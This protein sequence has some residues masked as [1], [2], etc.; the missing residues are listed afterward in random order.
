MRTR[1]CITLAVALLFVS[2]A[3]FAGG[4]GESA[5]GAAATA[6]AAEGNEAPMLAQMV[7]AGQLPPLEDRIPLE[8]KITNE[9]A[10]DQLDYEIGRYGGTMR[11][12]TSV[13]E[14]DADVFVMCNE[15][16]VNT[17]GIRGEVITGNI[18]KDYEVSSNQQEFTF[19]MREGLKWSDGEAVTTEDVSFAVEDFLYNEQLVPIFPSWLRSGGS[20]EGNPLELEVVD[21]Y[22]FKLKF[23]K[24]YGG[25]LI[26]VAI[27]GWRGYTDLLK[28]AHFLKNFHADYT[29]VENLEQ[30]IAERGFDKGS[31]WNLFNDVDATNW[32]LN[33]TAAIDF[34]RLYPWLLVESNEAGQRYE[35]NPY[36][37]KVDPA[38]NQLPYIDEIRSQLVQDIEMVNMKMIAGEVD[39]A[40]ESSSLV[41][42][43]LYRENE[44]RGNY[45]ALLAKMHVTPTDIFINQTYDDPTWRSVARD[46]RFRKALSLAL[47]R[48]EV[49]DA[50]YYGFAKPGDIVDPTFDPQQAEALLDEMGMKKGGDGFRRAP[51]GERFEIFLEVGGH[52]PDIVPLAELITEMWEDIGIDVTMKSVD[53]TLWSNRNAA[54]E[55]Q[56]TIIWTHTPLWYMGDW[57]QNLWG[58]AWWAWWI[59]GGKATESDTTALEEPPEEIKD[60]Y[61]MIDRLS[62]VSPEQGRQVAEDIGDVI[63]ENYHYL[64]HLSDVRQPLLVNADLGN[65]GSEGFAIGWNFSGE[66]FYYKQ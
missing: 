3:V 25:F 65:I 60:L 48:D 6:G 24:P 2:L 51:N 30:E 20:S 61:R 1:R 23:D 36:Y 26:R 44:E 15:P 45:K 4:Q 39:F 34:P 54:N 46:V 8:P 57:G 58:R 29:D 47:D 66:Q 62:V 17:P 37:F 33:K 13:V 31:W 64:I 18:V 53:Q 55:L 9:M 22:T 42:M 19:F 59:A 5:T 27:Q 11:T 28:P 43:P 12:V 35:R 7:A 56:S 41:K 49:I 50:I 63:G 21:E 32:E 16:L 10:E 14:W 38:G 52:A 40:R